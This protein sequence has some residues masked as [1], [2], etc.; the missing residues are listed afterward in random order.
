MNANLA[1]TCWSR[2]TSSSVTH[3][4]LRRH[5]GGIFYISIFIINPEMNESCTKSY[6]TH[7][8]FPA[9]SNTMIL[10]PWKTGTMIRNTRNKK[11]MKNTTVWMA[12]PANTTHKQAIFNMFTKGIHTHT[13]S[14]ILA[15]IQS[16]GWHSFT[17]SLLQQIPCKG[18]ILSLPTF[19]QKPILFLILCILK[20]VANK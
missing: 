20:Q 16:K 5:K 15:I 18:Q 6:R 10:R 14:S 2:V 3:T 17:F 11:Q 7:H 8:A 1:V 19:S 13:H 9:M 12:I 4:G